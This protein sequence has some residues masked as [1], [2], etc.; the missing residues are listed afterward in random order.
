MPHQLLKKNQKD[1]YA[2]EIQQILPIYSTY[3][4][5]EDDEDGIDSQEDD[6]DDEDDYDELS[7]KY[8]QEID[9]LVLLILLNS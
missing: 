1:S 5:D 4:D 7:Y 3:D 9:V 6:E 8:K 2:A